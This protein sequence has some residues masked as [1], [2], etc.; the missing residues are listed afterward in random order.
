MCPK[1]SSLDRHYRASRGSHSVKQYV[2]ILVGVTGMLSSYS[3]TLDLEAEKYQQDILGT[4]FNIA[5]QI[6]NSCL[7]ELL[8]RYKM[9]QADE[10]GK[11]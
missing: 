5:R 7:G 6:Y 1:R 9:M 11:I 4:R 3:L 2:G 10:E 8:K